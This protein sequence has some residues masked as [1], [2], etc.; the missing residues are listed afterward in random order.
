MKPLVIGFG[1]KARNGKDTCVAHLI[2]TYKDKYNM[3]R[4]AFANELKVELYDALVDGQ[5]AYWRTNK[6]WLGLPKPSEAYEHHLVGQAAS[7]KS[8]AEKVA[9]IEA[10]RT[11]EILHHLQ[12][13]GTAFRRAQSPFYW[14]AKLA[15]RIAAEK[16]QVALIADMRFKSEL[17]WV[18]SLG[19]I[20]VKVIRYGYTDPNRDPNHQ[21]EVE[22][23]GT[24]FD[25][26]IQVLDGEVDQ[27]KKDAVTVMEIIEKA[28]NPV[29]K[30]M[31]EVLN[32]QSVA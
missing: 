18:K 31:V 17:L 27:L 21:S 4:Y 10:N 11:P 22:L 25:F 1:Y 30:E 6:D 9:W 12:Q 3:K 28:M 23:D 8:V 19:G 7:T 15:Q 14:V 32:V 2:E 5:H 26:E 16:P 13:Y 20:T 29:S 24:K